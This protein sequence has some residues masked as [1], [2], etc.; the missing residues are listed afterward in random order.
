MT[1]T[2]TEK[3]EAPAGAVPPVKDGKEITA[4]RRA[5]PRFAVDIQVSV[6]SDKQS[7][8]AHTRDI[9]RSGLCLVS[10]QGLAKEK[11][12]GLELVLTFGEGGLSE[13]LH[14]RGKVV[15]CTAMFGH[16]QMGVKFLD[17]D[18]EQARNLEM[19]LGFLDGSLNAG[20]LFDEREETDANQKKK[21]PDPDDPF[22]P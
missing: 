13:P 19:F 4:S 2:N 22:R 7:V 14:M 5:H 9:S 3:T 6:S 10:T 17:P 16:Y 11:E 21:L 15:W 20:E 8:S 18:P 12:I 1:K